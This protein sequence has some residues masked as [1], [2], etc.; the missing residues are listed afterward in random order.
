M[1]CICC[2]SIAAAVFCWMRL[3]RPLI[4]S[5]VFRCAGGWRYLQFSRTPTL[6]QERSGKLSISVISTGQKLKLLLISPVK[7]TPII[8]H[9]SQ[10]RSQKSLKFSKS[11]RSQVLMIWT[12]IYINFIA[13]YSLFDNYWLII[14][15]KHMMITCKYNL[16]QHRNDT[17]TYMK[18]KQQCSEDVCFI[19]Q[20]L[21]RRPKLD[22]YSAQ[23]Q[24]C[25]CIKPPLQDIQ[26]HGRP[27]W[28]RDVRNSGGGVK[29]RSGSTYCGH[30]ETQET[31]S[32][33]LCRCCVALHAL[34]SI[35]CLLEVWDL[36]GNLEHKYHMLMLLTKQ[37]NWSKLKKTTTDVII[38][39]I[40][41]G[42]IKENFNFQVINICIFWIYINYT[43][44][45]NWFLNV[46]LRSLLNKINKE[47]FI[48]LYVTLLDL[49]IITNFCFWMLHVCFLFMSLLNLKI[50]KEIF[51]NY[52]V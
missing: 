17:T 24:A 12:A 29:K 7:K 36:H 34:Y 32:H 43:L 51:F 28:Y 41:H 8:L 45:L 9:L 1:N 49:H 46:F 50:L 2:A 47:I 5:C 6:W 26:W 52:I 3:L 44:F 31:E 21:L 39:I 42:Y 4:S 23:G 19:L 33:C 20:Y 13:L 16:N 35:S 25:V 40:I 48:I 27:N 15:S 11:Q 14:Y 22:E 37:D 18:N 10:K 30:A 38:K